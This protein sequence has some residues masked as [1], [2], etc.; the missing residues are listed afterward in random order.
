MKKKAKYFII[1]YFIYYTVLE[2]LCGGTLHDM[3]DKRCGKLLPRGRALDIA[4][5]LTSALK[6]LHE[7]LSSYTMILHRGII[8]LLLTRIMR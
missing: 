8:Y 5:Q 6:Y 3:L 2:E 1:V 4:Y 7:D